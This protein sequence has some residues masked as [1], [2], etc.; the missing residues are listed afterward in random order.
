[1]Q[2]FLNIENVKKVIGFVITSTVVSRQKGRYRIPHIID[3]SPPYAVALK[4]HIS[5][6]GQSAKQNLE[7]LIEELSDKFPPAVANAANAMEWHNSGLRDEGNSFE[8]GSSVADNEIKLS[9]RLVLEVLAG[10][11]QIHDVDDATASETSSSN[12][13]EEK[14][15]QGRLIENVTVQRLQDED[16]DYIT[17]VFGKP[18]PAI[19]EFK[20]K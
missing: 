4:L 10:R 2:H 12:H 19:S 8:G 16:D 6:S 14:L 5:D 20:G 11:K 9:A 15:N 17:F 13:F 18:D 1:M 7:L 3:P